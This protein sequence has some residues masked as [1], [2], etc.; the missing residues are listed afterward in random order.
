MAYLGLVP[1]EST[2]SD[3]RKQGGITKCGKPPGT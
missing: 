2:S 3:K 1:S